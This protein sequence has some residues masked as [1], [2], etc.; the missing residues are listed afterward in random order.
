MSSKIIAGAGR[1][2]QF[3]DYVFIIWHVLARNILSHDSRGSKEFAT[4]R[5][6]KSI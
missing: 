3:F 2:L 6:S 4:V 5:I 1:N